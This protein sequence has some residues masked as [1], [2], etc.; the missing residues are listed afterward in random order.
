ML[1]LVVI[2][3]ITSKEVLVE[4]DST[5]DA[6]DFAEKSYFKGDERLHPDY[7]DENNIDIGF[8]TYLFLI[9]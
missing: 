4:A 6:Q 1:Y 3:E 5:E 9:R 2:S 8:D 7:A